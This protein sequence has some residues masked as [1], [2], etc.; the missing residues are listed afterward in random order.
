[1]QDS[2]EDYDFHVDYYFRHQLFEDE[3][4]LNGIQSSVIV[5]SICNQYPK[6]NVSQTLSDDFCLN[7]KINCNYEDLN[8]DLNLVNGDDKVDLITIEE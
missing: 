3:P 4:N 2:C 7:K 6:F 5:G 1:M 8:E